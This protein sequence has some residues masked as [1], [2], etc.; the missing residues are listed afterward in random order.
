MAPGRR[1]RL[2]LAALQG[3]KVRWA[4]ALVVATVMLAAAPRADA[5]VRQYWVAAVPVT[6]NMVPNERDA[7]AGMT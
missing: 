2:A 5:K 6:W 1:A 3:R 4:A 7:I